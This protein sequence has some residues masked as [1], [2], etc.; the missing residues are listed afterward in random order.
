[1]A[2][3]PSG[4]LVIPEHAWRA[5]PADL[6]C[7]DRAISDLWSRPR[8]VVVQGD[9]SETLDQ[10]AREVLT[11]YQR[12]VP[13][14]NPHSAS[15]TFRRVLSGHR[16]MHDLA[17]SP[18]RADYD[19]ALDV[20]QWVLRLAPAAGLAVQLAALF[21]DVGRLVSEADRQGEPT[22]G[23]PLALE[24]AHAERGAKI[25]LEVL[26][27]CGV[28]PSTCTEAARLIREHEGPSPAALDADLKLLADADALSFFS[29]NSAGF[30]D[31]HGADPTRER[32]RYRLGRMSAAA[33]RRLADIRMREDVAQ[34]LAD[35]VRVEARVALERDGA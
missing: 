31:G 11:R 30:A 32:M 18:V 25:A 27:A 2:Q 34:Y 21:H 9:G 17:R 13:R 6:H 29:L 23:E 19:H 15:L 10:T 33:I 1:M 28:T 4:A 20:W 14:T 16:A 7:W 35:V 12:L 3:P 24:H 5:A 22:A 8:W 26:A